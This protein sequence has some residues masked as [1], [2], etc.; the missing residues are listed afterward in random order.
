MP[1]AV[2]VG[3]RNTP[4]ALYTIVRTEG[5]KVLW[6]GIGLTAARQGTN[7]AGKCQISFSKSCCSRV[8]ILICMHLVN[9]FAY[10][11]IR[12]ALVDNQPQYQSSGL[13]SWQTGLNGFLAGSLGPLANAPIDTLSML[14]LQYI[15]CI[16]DD[17]FRNSD[18]EKWQRRK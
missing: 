1:G 16:A 7:Q 6:S 10:T 5:V 18:S 11:R 4:E 2:A 14:Y 9:F 15:K 12:Q 13:P 3:Y 8:F 17:P